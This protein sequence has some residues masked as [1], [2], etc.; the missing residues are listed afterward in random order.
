MAL[1]WTLQNPA[2]T[3]TLI[4]AS[5]VSQ[6]NTNLEALNSPSFSEQEL[7]EIDKILKD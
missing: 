2:I 3:S 1:A 6:L 4:G 7:L 5:S